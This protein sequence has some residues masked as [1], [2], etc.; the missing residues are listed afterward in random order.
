MK[1]RTRR[2]IVR[3]GAIFAVLVVLLVALHAARLT[4][5]LTDSMPVGLY[6]VEP[7]TRPARA[8]DIV[9]VC[10]PPDAAALA[11][12]RH[13]LLRGGPCAHGAI[14]MIKLVAAVAG[15]TVEVQRDRITVNG[16]VLPHSA[17]LATD[18]QGKPLSHIPHGVYH[19]APGQLWLWTPNPRSWDSRYYGL[20]PERNVAGFGHL[21][22]AFAPWPYLERRK[23]G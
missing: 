20:V 16:I 2:R 11:V 3:L 10:P 22:L 19:L 13:Y 23:T 17:T 9:E 12:T 18:R 21:L 8:G 15:D 7:V 4:F 14:Y 6:R 5:N 1:E